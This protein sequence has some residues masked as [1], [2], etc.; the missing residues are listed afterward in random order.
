LSTIR[1]IG[2][3]WKRT[4]LVVAAVPGLRPTPDRV[5]ETLF[6]WLGQRLD[7]IS[8]LDLFA[9]SG[10]LGLEALSRGAREV[11]FV[12]SDRRAVRAIEQTLGR[13]GEEQVQGRAELWS[14]DALSALG[15]GARLGR[16]YDL[17]FLDPPYSAGLLERVWPLLGPVLAAEALIYVECG[18]ALADADLAAIATQLGGGRSLRAQKRDRAGQVHYHLLVS[19]VGASEA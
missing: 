18:A 4:P 17:V 11:L 5:R 13:L 8:C 16:R 9:G 12:E 15:R 1:I 10:A 19:T 7:G 6:N 14:S 3:A 2:G